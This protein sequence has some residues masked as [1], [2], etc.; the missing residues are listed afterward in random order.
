MTSQ[1]EVSSQSSGLGGDLR[2]RVSP[3][4]DKP[5]EK[6]K[7]RFPFFLQSSAS[8]V[9]VYLASCPP[10]GTNDEDIP[11]P[12]KAVWLRTRV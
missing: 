5:V 11:F 2:L 8:T 12:L 7:T 6:T 9:L 3:G 10:R 4:T 1:P